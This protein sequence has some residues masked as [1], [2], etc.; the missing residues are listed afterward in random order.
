MPIYEYRCE[1]CGA[2]I[3]V[4]QQP[5][6][7]SP[8]LC[9]YR[10]RLDPADDTDGLRGMGRLRRKLAV[11]GGVISPTIRKDRP[12]LADAERAGFSTWVNEGGKLV[13]ATGEAG[14]KVIK[15]DDGS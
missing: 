11:P 6:D 9:G 3:E 15:G 1:D 12:T 10:C 13:R 7:P 2:I 4:F 14:P 8:H 5:G